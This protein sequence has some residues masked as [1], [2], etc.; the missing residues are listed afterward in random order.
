MMDSFADINAYMGHSASMSY[1]ISSNYVYVVYVRV[2]IRESC[3]IG[4]DKDVHLTP[5]WDYVQLARKLTLHPSLQ[6]Q[7]PFLDSLYHISSC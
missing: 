4:F 1:G 3:S 6:Y 2:N 7:W 5:V